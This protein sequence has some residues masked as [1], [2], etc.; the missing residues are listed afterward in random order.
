MRQKS[1]IACSKSQRL[2]LA[3]CVAPKGWG[4]NIV[5]KQADLSIERWTGVG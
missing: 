4:K 1:Q 2:D 5:E 3:L